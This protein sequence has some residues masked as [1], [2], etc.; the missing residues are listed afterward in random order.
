VTPGESAV[1]GGAFPGDSLPTF[2][3]AVHPGDRG[4]EAV[5]RR[6]RL[7]DPAVIAR[8][9]EDRVILDPRTLPPGALEEVAEALDRAGAA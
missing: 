1:G 6:L 4:A 2:V 9:A 8:V 3:V 5:A 7:G